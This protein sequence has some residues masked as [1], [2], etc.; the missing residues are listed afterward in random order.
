MRK[1]EIQEVASPI[2]G[3]CLKHLHAIKGSCG[4]DHARSEENDFDRLPDRD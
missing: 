3:I 4:F 2:V 1:I